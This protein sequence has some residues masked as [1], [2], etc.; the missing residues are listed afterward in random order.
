MISF[1]PVNRKSF[2]NYSL[3]LNIITMR[4]KMTLGLLL[5]GS[6]LACLPSIVRAANPVAGDRYYFGG[7]GYTWVTPADPTPEPGG[8]AEDLREEA[9]ELDWAA[10]NPGGDPSGHPNGLDLEEDQAPF[11]AGLS[12][13]LGAGA[14]AGLKRAR[15]RKNLA[16]AV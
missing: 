7:R 10:N 8:I 13:L 9:A 15:A 16:A 1:S 11:D 2:K 6:A 12:I 3:T 4:L 14:L 5:L